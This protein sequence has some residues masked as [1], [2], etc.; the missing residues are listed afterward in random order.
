[1]RAGNKFSA[2][3]EKLREAVWAFA[4]WLLT[5]VGPESYVM[6]NDVD[7]DVQRVNNAQIKLS[8]R[9]NFGSGLSWYAIVTNTQESQMAGLVMCCK[10]LA[11]EEGERLSRWLEVNQ[12]ERNGFLEVI[13][14]RF[15]RR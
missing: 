15:G 13:S 14:N 4:E 11:G 10:L 9:A 7:W 12:K 2:T 1:M 8:F 5:I 6:K 3:N